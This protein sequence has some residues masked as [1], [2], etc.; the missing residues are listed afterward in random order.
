MQISQVMMQK[1]NQILIKYYEKMSQLI[2]ITSPHLSSSHSVAHK[3]TLLFLHL[4][5]SLA[6]A[7]A[8]SQ[9]FQPAIILSFST[10]RRQVVLGR[11][12]F[13]LP[14]GVQVS[15]VAQW[16]SL[17]IL[18]TCPKNLHLL[19]YP[20]TSC[21]F[22]KLINRYYVRSKYAQASFKALVLEGI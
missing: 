1:L 14:I 8:S 13:L 16:C 22:V 21:S 15:V 4:S 7:L 2:W 10:V 18:R 19:L 17:G 9:D 11:P 5:V 6:M 20:G 3:A 12:T